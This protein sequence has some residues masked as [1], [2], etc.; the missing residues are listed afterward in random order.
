MIEKLNPKL[1]LP[2]TRDEVL[3][4]GWESL[5][6][7][8]VS[9]DAYVDHPSFGAAIIGRLI[10]FLGFRVAI[11]PQP[12]WQD[13]LR[14]FKKLGKPRLFFGV[15]AGNMDSMINHY[16]ALKR[17]RS[18]DAYTPGGRAGARPDYASI[19]YSRILKKLYPDVPVILGG[20]EASMRR[21]THYDYWSDSVKPSILIDSG[22]DM[23]VYGMAEKSISQIL[24]LLD[25]GVPLSSIKNVPQT[26]FKVSKE[27]DI[28]EIKD[29]ITEFLPSHQSCV[30]DKYE[31][32]KS[33]RIFEESGNQLK[34]FRLVQKTGEDFVVAN[35]PVGTIG[36]DDMDLYYGLPFTRLPHPK[37]KK[38]PPIP[39]YEMIKFSVTLH[40]GCFGG[41]SFCTISAHQGKF[42][43]SRSEQSVL[44]EVSAIAA[45]PDFKG[46]I[47]DLGGPSANMYK[48]RGFDLKIC[49]DCK[50][51]SCIFP[52]IC[53]N[54]N[55]DHRPLVSLYKR[56]AAL[57][58]IKKI[59][60][61]SGVRYDMLV[62]TKPSDQ[63]R[64]GLN[65]YLRDLIEKRVSGRLK[66]APE[67]T[68]DKVLNLMR[69][70]SFKIFKSF[71]DE[72]F[73]ICNITGLNQQLIPYFISGHPATTKT[74][75]AELADELDKLNAHSDQV[76]EFTPTPMT[77]ATTIY[78]SGINP[79]S[80]EKVFV[81]KNHNE[82][83]KQ[84]EFFFAKNNKPVNKNRKPTNR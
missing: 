3:K 33:F 38:K 20:V 30:K 36:Q 14:D 57:P 73:R 47:S 10:E 50:R 42:I 72:F 68:S 1:F 34:Q 25:K 19:A 79:Y 12:N 43:S 29:Y 44:S 59:V 65:D 23:I 2:I 16:T 18:S 5:D 9:G 58:G 60:V 63:K 82:K 11:I 61:S 6:V 26:V 64:F 49:Y 37:Y 81:E 77:L 32:A 28:P 8:I 46:Y 7:I 13:D 4:L 22:A 41:C 15:T 35:P 39:A 55:Y 24:K 40:R 80:G 67:H 27:E 71:N 17:L 48:M 74:E 21:F 69:K 76:Q 52:R 84:K 56:A 45:M 70:P 66:V 83:R 51:H 31:F 78:Y 62:D 53:N 75:M 54:L